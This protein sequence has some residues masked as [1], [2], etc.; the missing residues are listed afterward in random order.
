MWHASNK[1]KVGKE[2]RK[3]THPIPPVSHA[4]FLRVQKENR[5]LLI[6]F[7]DLLLLLFVTKKQSIKILTNKQILFSNRFLNFYDFIAR[8]S[9]FWI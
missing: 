5:H 1:E 2:Q 9:S 6:L 8:F 7:Y 3:Y 4:L